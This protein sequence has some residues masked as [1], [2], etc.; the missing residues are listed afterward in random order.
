MKNTPS[1]TPD[2]SKS[3]QPLTRVRRRGHK[4]TLADAEAIAALVAKRANEREACA[5]LEIPYS[6]WMH[7]KAKPHNAE[8]FSVVLDR[9]RGAKLDAHLDNIEKFSKDDFRASIAYLEKTMPEKYSSRAATIEVHNHAPQLTDAQ[10]DT[11][12]LLY[13]KQKVIES[14]PAPKQMQDA[15]IVSSDESNPS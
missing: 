14:A 4:L 2:T 11:I 8:K 10:M 7:W 15:Q 9:I 12:I 3:A 6:T 1:E 5:V 13:Q